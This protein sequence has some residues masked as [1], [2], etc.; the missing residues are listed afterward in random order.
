[1]VGADAQPDARQARPANG[2]GCRGFPDGCRF[3]GFVHSGSARNA[4]GPHG[5]FALR[6]DCVGFDHH[7]GGTSGPKS[8]D[9]P[10]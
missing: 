3:S 8:R 9:V 6:V 10:L 2:P 1:M 7:P 4:R 5:R